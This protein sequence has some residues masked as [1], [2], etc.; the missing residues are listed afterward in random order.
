MSTEIREQRPFAAE[1]KFLLTPAQ[2]DAIRD[3]VRPRL[4]PDP[5]GSGEDG[6]RYT[7]TSLYCETEAQD[8]FF[9]RGSFGRSKYRIR[10][11]ATSDMVF[12]ERKLRTKDLLSKRRSLVPIDEL[13]HLGDAGADWPKGWSGA[14]FGHR[15]AA[16]RMRPVCQV[17]YDRVARLAATPY[18]VARLTLDTHIRAW[19]T[20]RFEFQDGEPRPV[21]TDRVILEMKYRVEMPAVFKALVEE[22]RLSPGRVSKYRLSMGALSLVPAQTAEKTDSCPA[23]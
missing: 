1:V 5:Y 15:I 2:G 19:V 17:A 10:R 9:R 22:F 11:Y 13:S 14:W 23:S 6:D 21:L 4:T 16:R 20:E 7:I 3:W 12:L 8:V 18:G